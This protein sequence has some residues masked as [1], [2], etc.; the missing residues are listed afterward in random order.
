MKNKKN[1]EINNKNIENW[2]RC[3]SKLVG[4]LVPTGSYK[5]APLVV[6]NDVHS[7]LAF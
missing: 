5:L 4:C 1:N 2:V 3:N 6:G 7:C